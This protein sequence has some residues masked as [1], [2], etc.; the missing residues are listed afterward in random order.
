[1]VQ[2]PYSSSW[3][4]LS[5]RVDLYRSMPYASSFSFSS[6]KGHSV[7]AGAEFCVKISEDTSSDVQ[8]RTWVHC[9]GRRM[10]ERPRLHQR[11]S[12]VVRHQVAENRD[13]KM[14]RQWRLLAA[15]DGV[16]L[17]YLLHSWCTSSLM[18]SLSH[19]AS[20]SK[21]LSITSRARKVLSEAL[22]QSWSECVGFQVCRPYISVFPLFTCL[23]LQHLAAYLALFI[24]SELLILYTLSAKYKSCRVC[25]RWPLC[26]LSIW[27][28]LRILR[29]RKFKIAT[30][31]SQVVKTRERVSKT[32]TI[33]ETTKLWE[34][35][36]RRRG[37]KYYNLAGVIS[38]MTVNSKTEARW[39]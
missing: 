24:L 28:K 3:L 23:H 25:S 10:H 37:A 1:M 7:V 9:V 27:S 30:Y 17:S 33:W 13:Q 6:V 22:G 11:A 2:I 20:L 39:L 19:L 18:D 14:I 29:R 15:A 12:T 8:H 5:C 21:T 34:D 32:W 36:E 26:R 4:V 35:G 16:G 31:Y 38:N